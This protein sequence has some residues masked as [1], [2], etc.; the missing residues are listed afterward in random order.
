MSHQAHLDPILDDL[1]TGLR[2]R[3]ER[4]RRV[5]AAVAA[6]AAAVVV[7]VSGAS[8]LHQSSGTGAPGFTPAVS[9]P[10]TLAPVS[11]GECFTSLAACGLSRG[12]I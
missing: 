3:S 8:A 7:A 11:S 2:R 6:S 9:A 1:R 10:A 5:R 4:R 12:Q